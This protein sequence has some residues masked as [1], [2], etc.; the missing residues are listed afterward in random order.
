MPESDLAKPHGAALQLSQQQQR[1][2]AK[3]K[4]ISYYL[5]ITIARLGAQSFPPN[6]S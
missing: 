1:L 5:L 4:W 3:T 2:L 6:H